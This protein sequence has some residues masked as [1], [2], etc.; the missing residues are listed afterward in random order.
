M[1][2]FDGPPEIKTIMGECESCDYFDILYIHR[3][4]HSF[5]CKE[6]YNRTN[7]GLRNTVTYEN[8]Q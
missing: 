5:L 4:N 7:W 1:S 6:C 8:I 3:W 2:D